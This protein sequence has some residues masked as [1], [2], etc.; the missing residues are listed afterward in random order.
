MMVPKNA[1]PFEILNLVIQAFYTLFK[2]VL[3]HMTGMPTI[4]LS[5]EN[6]DSH[7]YKGWF[8]FFCVAALKRAVWILLSHTNESLSRHP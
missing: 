4:I 6:G 7:S 2:E 1:C 8:S 5:T 3:F